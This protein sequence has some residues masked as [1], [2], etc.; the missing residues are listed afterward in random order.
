[1]N[2]AL[3]FSTFLLL[4]LYS[5]TQTFENVTLEQNIDVFNSLS[6][7]G[8]GVS[9]ADFN[10]D[11]WDDLSFA[12]NVNDPV[13][14]VNNEGSYAEIDLGIENTEGSDM[15][16][17][18][19]A[20]YD[21]DGDQDLVIT[22][23]FGTMHLY[24]NDGNL[25]MTDVTES[26]G[27]SIQD[28]RYYGPCW[29][30]YNN[31]GCLDL[32]VCKYHNPVIDEGYEFENRLYKNNCDGT[33]TDVTIEAGVS[34]GV[35]ASFQS[36][37]F[38]YDN[39]GWQDI[40]I[41][42]DRIFLSNSLYHNNGDGT[43]TSTGE[44]SGTD[45]MLDAM[46]NTCGDFDNDGDLDIYITNTDAWDGNVLYQNNG[47]LTFDNIASSAGVTVDEIGWGALWID[48]NNNTLQDLYVS[49]MENIGT[50]EEQ[51]Y[52]YQN[53]G[54]ATFTEI[55]EQTNLL[56]NDFAGTFAV[57]MGD[58]NNDGYP[59]FVQNNLDPTECRLFENSGGPNNYL[60]VSV[61]GTA[62]NK[63]GIGSWIEIWIDGQKYIRYTYCG[64]NYLGQNSDREFFGLGTAEQVDSLNVIWLSGHEDT[65]Y[66]IDANQTLHIIEG[67]SLVNQIS[68]DGGL[69]ICGEGTLTL[70]AS[71][72]SSYLWSTGDTTQ[73]IAVS[74]PG[75]FWLTAWNELGVEVISDTVTVSLFPAI[76]IEEEISH[77]SCFGE[78]DGGVSINTT[79]ESLI[80]SISWELEGDSTILYDLVAG[81]YFYSVIDMNGCS[82]QDSIVITEPEEITASINTTDVLCY[83]DSTGTVSIEP[84]G[85]SGGFTIDYFNANPDALSEGD[86]SVSLL[87]SSS[88]SQTFEYSIS[89]PDSISI[90]VTI[91]DI[92][93]S[94]N[95]S[96]SIIINGG[97]PP[98]SSE[99]SDGTEGLIIDDVAAGD[100]TVYVVDDND[101]TSELSISITGIGEQNELSTVVLYPNPASERVNIEFSNK[102]DVISI[103]LYDSYG[104]LIAQ[105]GADSYQSAAIS[106]VD[107]SIL[108]IIE[109]GKITCSVQG[110]E[111]G[112]YIF[113]L[114]SKENRISIPLIV[115]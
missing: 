43:F 61:E 2:R 55:M 64:E 40:Y 99:W 28:A 42:N 21:N 18:I 76:E 59:D 5:H 49:T 12:T 70:E 111:S 107:E 63:D 78:N 62:S 73:N 88:C 75:Q 92:T 10:Q 16:S 48:Y 93:D 19:W 85:G 101:C 97:T 105:I 44:Q 25:N 115:E 90:D 113:E 41:I 109:Q 24:N 106:E 58:I 80:E 104:R 69:G 9:F 110:L 46:S 87:D 83:G 57:A 72:F 81:T 45:D 22:Y 100:Y 65:F 53:N 31:D 77:V 20:D 11:G 36:I 37:F 95:G 13:F 114:V 68:S 79:S 29:G 4:S 71:E 50:I 7:F 91:N 112:K 17:L 33:F 54:D 52:L 67:S 103:S 38:D 89:E 32:Y 98:Y 14:Y 96:A 27:I 15:K 86:Y 34:D 6:T 3:L 60:K 66:N 30:D 102:I 94:Q 51:N 47:D 8:N 35:S 82:A 26:S 23:D 39:D 84:M 108:E 1:M 56:G 74:I